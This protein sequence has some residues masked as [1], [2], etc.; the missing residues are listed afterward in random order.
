MKVKR[1]FGMVNYFY[2]NINDK[3]LDAKNA[4]VHKYVNTIRSNRSVKV[5]K[6]VKYVSTIG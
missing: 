5:A 4:E 6:G 1:D 3:Y 2:V